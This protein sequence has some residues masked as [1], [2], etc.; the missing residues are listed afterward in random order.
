MSRVKQLFLLLTVSS[1]IFGSV[2]VNAANKTMKLPQHLVVKLVN[3]T[4]YMV[5]LKQ[6][7]KTNFDVLPTS[8][9]GPFKYV[10]FYADQLSSYESHFDLYYQISGDY[11][12]FCHFMTTIFDDG[13]VL[14]SASSSGHVDCTARRLGYNQVELTIWP[15]EYYKLAKKA[16]KK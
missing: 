1:L 2:S 14:T 8:F 3:R 11:A 4:D 13:Y 9:L 7:S 12:S 5:D 16:A 6:Y 10:N 15:S